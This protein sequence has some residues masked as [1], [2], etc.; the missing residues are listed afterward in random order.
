MMLCFAG[1]YKCH[2]IPSEVA[3]SMMTLTVQWIWGP[4]EATSLFQ[5][6]NNESGW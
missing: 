4:Y 2:V 6:E 3:D 1:M 5:I